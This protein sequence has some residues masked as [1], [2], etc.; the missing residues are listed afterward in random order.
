MTIITKEQM[1]EALGYIIDELEYS[2]RIKDS[3]GQ[4]HCPLTVFRTIRIALEEH[5]N[6]R[7]K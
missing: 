1:E 5:G 7:D 3:W 4:L 6:E 2:E